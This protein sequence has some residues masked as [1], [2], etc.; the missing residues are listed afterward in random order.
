MRLLL[1]KGADPKI[2]TF[3]GTNALMMAAG[4][5]W[6]IGQTY[7]S[8]WLEAVQLCLDL[9]FDVNAVNQMGLPPCTA[10]PIAVGRRHRSCWRAAAPSRRAGQ[11]RAHAAS[12]GRGRV[13]GH[14]LAHGQAVHDGAARHAH[15]EMKSLLATAARS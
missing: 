10:P 3:N 13:P 4:V 12:V 5:N 2:T 1:A 14:Q 7:G 15:E 6:V 8:R 9:G 11:G